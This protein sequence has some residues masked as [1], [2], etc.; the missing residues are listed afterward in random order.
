MYLITAPVFDSL[1][2]KAPYPS[3]Q[4][5]LR[6]CSPIHRDELALIRVHCLG[7]R[8]GGREMEQDMH[9]VVRPV[10]RDRFNSLVMADAGHIGPKL[11]LYFFR[12]ELVSF[13]G[14][15]DQVDVDAGKGMGHAVFLRGSTLYSPKPNRAAPP[16]LRL[17]PTAYPPLVR[18]AQ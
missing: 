3:C 18:W 6:L 11:G 16:G 15:E 7:Q 9:M 13:F 1:T 10:D 17:F 4:A 8:H 14:A 12:N 2:L 5:N